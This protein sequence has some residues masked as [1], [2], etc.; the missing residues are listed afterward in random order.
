MP[1]KKQPAGACNRQAG[2]EYF[3]DGKAARVRI[4]R[5]AGEGHDTIE[6]RKDP[7]PNSKRPW[8]VQLNNFPSF[9]ITTPQL[10]WVRKFLKIALRQLADRGGS[11]PWPLDVLWMPQASWYRMVARLCTTIWQ[12]GAE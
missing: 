3:A 11:E 12:G 1:R 7:E 6:L 2:P 10:L 9:S 8:L 5:Q 4:P